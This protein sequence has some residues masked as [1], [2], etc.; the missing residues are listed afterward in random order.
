MKSPERAAKRAWGG[1]GPAAT[2]GTKRGVRPAGPF[3]VP[4]LLEHCR[5]PCHVGV[6]GALL[7]AVADSR[8]CTPRVVPAD[9]F[10]LA[11]PSQPPR[12]LQFI[13]S[14]VYWPSNHLRLGLR[15]QFGHACLRRAH[16]TLHS[17]IHF[18]FSFSSSRFDRLERTSAEHAARGSGARRRARPRCRTPGWL[19]IPDRYSPLV[20]DERSSVSIEVSTRK[21]AVVALAHHAPRAELEATLHLHPRLVPERQVL[22]LLAVL[23]RLVPRVV[24]VRRLRLRRHMKQV[25]VA[26][27]HDVE[28]LFDLTQSYGKIMQPMRVLLQ[29]RCGCF[30]LFHLRRD[31]APRPSSCSRSR[32]ACA[33][34]GTAG[35]ARV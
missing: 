25:L 16:R 10:T 15:L 24:G 34:R 20:H 3:L 14:L 18:A 30:T 8:G 31:W 22:P 6:P 11:P 12:L 28:L 5:V 13:S 33:S 26:V 27:V 23:H 21:R 4:T 29:Q 35:R 7:G 17:L 2:E 9:L 1:E 19:S 32:T